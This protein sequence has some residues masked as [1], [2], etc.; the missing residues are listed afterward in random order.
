MKRLV[1]IS[2]ALV[3]LLTLIM[4][5]IAVPVKADVTVEFQPNAS[6]GKDSYILNS[7]KDWNLGA[8]TGLYLQQDS[9]SSAWIRTLLSFNV[10]SLGSVTVDSATLSLYCIF[11]DQTGVETRLYRTSRSDWVEGSGT[12]QVVAGV[13]WNDYNGGSWAS[14]GGDYNG[15]VPAYTLSNTVAIN[16]WQTW[17]A[18]DLV[19]DAIDNRNSIVEAFL[20]MTT[21][22]TGSSISWIYRS[23][24]YVDDPLLRPKL[25]VTYSL[26]TSGID[27]SA[28]SSIEETTVT[29]GGDITNAINCTERG[30]VWDTTSRSKPNDITAPGA[31]DYANEWTESGTYG[32]G[33]FT[34]GLT[35]LTKGEKYYFRACANSSIGGWNYGDELS[36][37]TK[38][39]EPTSLTNTSQLSTAIGLSWS[40]GTGALNTIVRYSTSTYPADYSSGTLAYNSTGTSTTVS[41]LTSETQ[42]YFRAW[43]FASGSSAYS[44]SY[45]SVTA[46]TTE[47]PIDVTT[48]DCET[49]T[50]YEYYISG[51]TSNSSTYND[52]YLA[53]TFTTASAHSIMA[54]SLQLYRVGSPGTL[55]IGFQPTDTSGHPTGVDF[56]TITTNG[57][58]ITDL[59]EGAWYCFDFASEVSMSNNVTYAIVLS[60][61]DSDTT[62]Y[63]NWFYN[64]AGSYSGGSYLSSSDSGSSWTAT[65][66][67]DLMFKVYGSGSVGIED[68]AIFANVIEAGDMYI[69]IL[70]KVW[71][72]TEYPL[73][74]P[75]QYYDVVFSTESG[76]N[77]VVKRPLPA[78]G[79]A[80][81]SLYLSPET[82]N[83]YGIEWQGDDY[84]ISIE[85]P[86]NYVWEIEDTDW[87]DAY[88]YQLCS[89]G[90]VIDT[91]LTL[92]TYY[93]VDLVLDEW[94]GNALDV[95][96]LNVQGG[97]MFQAGMA[98]LEEI[99][100][101]IFLVIEHEFDW[102]DPEYSDT[103]AATH[104]WV[105]ILGT[106]NTSQIPLAMNTIGSVFNLGGS[107]IVG[108][109]FFC[110]VIAMGAMVSGQGIA[111]TG[112][113]V[114]LA[115]VMLSIGAWLGIIAYALIAIA[116]ILTM[117]FF[118][119]IIWWRAT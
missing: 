9:I 49:Q 37:L 12:G 17:D 8:G 102:S 72:P 20:K 64:P 78:W 117:L 51:G 83:A 40:K 7:Q 109:A 34:H 50:L 61:S 91:A 31:S 19:Q 56:M 59:P 93:G 47:V 110:S 2:V 73:S 88:Q 71:Q 48:G 82:V 86:A 101:E 15:T 14:V 115:I 85:G 97:L 41:S 44:D 13:S 18:T 55:T 46:N 70:Y 21:E 76:A 105:T 65:T 62:N 108:L 98:D 75:Q 22:N 10:S 99:C 53:Q 36:F 57:S 113:F 103:W 79:Y 106:S 1:S 54:V 42:Y 45:S 30:F 69:A 81:I 77:P 6:A 96:I 24:D 104:N 118:V 80:P 94:E 52:T 25:S 100:S 84:I 74:D 11:S 95:P 68:V 114:A 66:A 3:V 39:D 63:V 107:V 32:N 90:W 23:S 111:R 119:W 35:S 38:P 5:S 29:L 27:T 28:A 58:A 67:R 4:A 92:E 116:A 33:S 16:N 60:S 112:V 89:D 26:T 43:S 87:M